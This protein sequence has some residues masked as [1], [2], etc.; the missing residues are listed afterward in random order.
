M[1]QQNRVRNEKRYTL[2][3]VVLN[4]GVGRSGDAITIA[5][6]ALG[7][8]SGKKSCVRNA[9]EAQ[10]D[11]GVRKGEAH[12]GIS[13]PSAGMMRVLSWSGSWRQ[14]GMSFNGRFL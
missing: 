1:S 2:K 6:K 5:Q 8:I 3:K 7:Q 14:R 11:W 9:K 13:P 12:R 10:R 4:M